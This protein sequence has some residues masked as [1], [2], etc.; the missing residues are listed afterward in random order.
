MD[1][2]NRDEAQD[3]GPSLRP[4][5]PVAVR[6]GLGVMLTTALVGL[7]WLDAH[8]CC[9][10]GLCVYLAPGRVF[11]VVAGV[12]VGIGLAEY[13]RMARA[14]GAQIST[15][16]LVC[17]GLAVHVA[18]SY[19][20]VARSF[21]RGPWL[22]DWSYATAGAVVLSMVVLARLWHRVLLGRIEGTIRDVSAALLGLML[23][24]CMIG[25]LMYLHVRMY[26][27]IPLI[28][29]C[30]AGAISAYFIGKYFGRMPLCPRVSPR[31]TVAGGVAAVVAG[32]IVV[33]LYY[34]ATIQ[35]TTTFTLDEWTFLTNAKW[36][37]FGLIVAV[38]AV[39][40]DLTF[41]LLK[42]DSG[43]KDSGTLLPGFGG[44]LDMLDDILLTAPVAL[45]AHLIL[46]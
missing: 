4:P 3:A 12:L 2:T 26:M 10:L 20:L 11:M 16:R 22:V 40:G 33:Q 14:T 1:Q 17:D 9:Y 32:L 44:V 23:V 19:A 42:R 35:N 36:L 31:K 25:C 13:A 43:I 8:L 5:T 46:F 30:K 18:L 24:P 45:A 34:L 41:S 6:I 37:L 7:L 39:M 38:A 29:I 28:V 21:S 27:A 15:P